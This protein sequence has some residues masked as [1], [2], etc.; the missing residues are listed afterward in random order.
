MFIQQKKSYSW[1]ISFLFLGL[2]PLKSIAE[3]ESCG[4]DQCV[5]V[6]DSGSTGSRAHLYRY[7]NKDNQPSVIELKHRENSPGLA[8]IG[9]DNKLMD[10]YLNELMLG[11]EQRVAVPVYVYS[12]AGMRLVDKTAQTSIYNNVQSWFAGHQSFQLIE[13]KT[14]SGKDEGLFGWAAVNYLSGTFNGTNNQRI[15][16]MDFGGASIQVAFPIKDIAN[17]VDK[18][19]VTKLKIAGK[20]YL[21]YAHSFLGMGINEVTRQLIMDEKCFAKSYPMPDGVVGNGDNVQ[22]EMDVEILSNNLHK[23]N[24]IKDENIIDKAD[25]W[26]ALGALSYLAKSKPFQSLHSPFIIKKV[27]Q[28]GQSGVCQMN[29]AELQA[30]NPND[31]YLYS[32]CLASAYYYAVAVQ[33]YGLNE[34]T[35]IY[36]ELDN[37]DQSIDWTYGV[38]LLKKM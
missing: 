21:V 4:V 17:A 3:T 35:K 25:K 14:I 10:K 11:L 34:S 6:I 31:K 33:G 38:V 12:T 8:K 13:A 7:S 36:T 15:G 23:V 18:S 29:W 9:L 32:T 28:L 20:K 22:C 24:Q 27:Y 2:M 19:S 16:V 1:L 30:R 37:K 5:I 26:V